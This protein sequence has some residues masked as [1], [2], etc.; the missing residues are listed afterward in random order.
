MK[1]QNYTTRSIQSVLKGAG[2]FRMILKNKIYTYAILTLM[3]LAGLISCE[4]ELSVLE[5]APFPTDAEVFID[6]FGSSVEPQSF[7]GT[8]L[9]ALQTDD[10]EVYDGT[11]SIVIT[12][13][14]PGDPSGSTWSGGALVA[15]LARDLSEYNALTFWAKASKSLTLNTVGLGNDN[16]APNPYVAEIANL[17]LTTNWTQYIIPIPL[18]DKLLQEQGMFYYSEAQEDGEGATIW[19]DEIQ[20]ES[21]G[22]IAHPSFSFASENLSVY[23]NAIISIPAVTVTFDV[24]G[25][26]VAV[27]ASSEYLTFSSSDTNIVAV[28]SDGTMTAMN[29]GNATIYASLGDPSVS[30]SLVIAVGEAPPA[31]DTAAPTPIVAPD[32]VV[33]IYSNAY[34]SVT[35]PDFYTYWE[36][37]TAEVQ[38]VS[39]AGNETMQFLNLNF[40]GIDFS[41]S[42]LVDASA[43]TTFH[44][45]VWT[46]DPSASPAAFKILLVDFGADGVYAGTDNS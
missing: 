15:G 28:D 34:T 1:F 25:S 2:D 14:G 32:S 20:F 3:V 36:F 9:D 8:K 43:M 44:M 7:L 39:I 37:S 6:G 23:Q 31:P 46:P 18:S 38:E 29:I 21:L 22:T 42:Q 41:A 30:D 24:D 17:P 27:N 19:L 13:P 4:R 11:H 12:I 45:D 35:A 26:N 16:A 10:S 40:A 33:S 5:P